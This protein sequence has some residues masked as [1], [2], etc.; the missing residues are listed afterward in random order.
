MEAPTFLPPPLPEVLNRRLLALDLAV[1]A[2]SADLSLGETLK[3]IV[4]AAVT[5]VDAEYGALGV[6][7][8]NGEMLVEFVTVGMSAEAEARIS[9]RPQGHG[10]LGVIMRG[11]HAVRLTELSR[12]SKSSGF[13]AGHPRMTSF[14]GVPIRHKGKSLGNLYLTNKLSSAEFSEQDQH[15]IEQLAA[16]AAIAIDNA[17]LYEQVQQLRVVEERQRIGMDLHDGIIQSIYAV[18]LNLELVNSLLREG[19]A[20][21]ASD[22]VRGAIDSLNTVIRDIRAYILD[23]RPRRFEGDNLVPALRQLLDEFRGNTL[24][25]VELRADPAVEQ[26]LTL[27]GRRALFHIAQEALSNAARHSRATRVEIYL[28]EHEQVI[29]LVLQDNG[30]G[31]DA[32]Q[33]ERRVGHG[34]VNMRD[35]VTAI[36]GHCQITSQAGAGTTVRVRVPKTVG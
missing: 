35:R 14:L 34:L 28:I 16:H 11:H 30:Q 1:L 33:T 5:L 22:R 23:L 3:R 6:P 26:T 7:D 4:T 10:L 31:F 17:R 25:S 15:L 9:H 20:A 24:M 27:E 36:G 32:A 18:G 2:I 19:D 8:E 29:E 21:N 12:H 13:P